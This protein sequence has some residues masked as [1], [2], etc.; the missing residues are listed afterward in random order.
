V[1]HGFFKTMRRIH[2]H[3]AVK[4]GS[5]F[6]LN[7]IIIV[8]SLGVFAASKNGYFHIFAHTQEFI[9]DVQAARKL[10][11]LKR[12]QGQLNQL[13][14]SPEERILFEIRKTRGGFKIP[15]I[16]VPS[17]WEGNILKTTIAIICDP[18]QADTYAKTGKTIQ[19]RLAEITRA[20]PISQ[21]YAIPSQSQQY[22]AKLPFA[23][24]TPPFD[25]ND[26]GFFKKKIY[27]T[28]FEE[29][30]SRIVD[31]NDGD[32]RLRWP[33]AINHSLNRAHPDP[34]IKWNYSRHDEA[35]DLT[36]Y[37]CIKNYYHHAIINRLPDLNTPRRRVIYKQIYREL[38]STAS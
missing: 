8:R 28:A 1:F 34:T 38:W 18:D 30:R 3:F 15:V 2:I 32:M 22:V 16:V 6:T 36:R 11:I 25:T 26:L 29:A 12:I 24:H 9:P 35:G 27:E 23:P 7:R 17:L 10:D 13:K 20:Y 14:Q 33:H 5:A 31:S 4:R 37:R 19:D 21:P